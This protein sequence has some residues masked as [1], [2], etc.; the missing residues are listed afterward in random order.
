MYVLIEVN[1]DGLYA[2]TCALVM[3]SED[4]N[5]LERRML[6]RYCDAISGPF[7]Y[8]RPLSEEDRKYCEYDKDHASF[9]CDGCGELVEWF[10]FDTNDRNTTC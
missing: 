6:E 7:D 10:I 5:E 9:G 2:D 8:I 1:H 3:A 4:H